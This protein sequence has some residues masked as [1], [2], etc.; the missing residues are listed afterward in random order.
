[1]LGPITT[2][3]TTNTTGIEPFWM[4]FVVGMLLVNVID[5]K[6]HHHANV[7]VVGSFNKGV[8]F[9]LSSEFGL[10]ASW[11][12]WPISMESRNIVHTICSLSC[13]FSS[14]IEWRQPK[15]S[16]TQFI[17]ITRFNHLGDTS[18]VTTLPISPL[19]CTNHGL[20]VG[21]IAIDKSVG[22]D[23]V[24]ECILPFKISTRPSPKWYK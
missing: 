11:L 12:G 14:S 23:H 21:C 19:C 4:V 22:H 8:E 6:I 3:R 15:R 17:E 5:N 13:S 1:M 16:N 2:R 18:E 24:D 20:I 7:T 10:N 9:F